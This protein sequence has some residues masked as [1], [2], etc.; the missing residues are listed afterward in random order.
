MRRYLIAGGNEILGENI[1][2]LIYGA[3][4]NV[5]KAFNDFEISVEEYVS[6]KENK[7]LYFGDLDY[8]GIVIYEGLYN[9]VKDKYNIAP[10]INGY[11]QMIDKYIKEE[12]RLPKTKEG[13][14]RNIKNIFLNKFNA[15]YRKKISKILQQ[16]LYIPQEILN[17]KELGM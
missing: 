11:E 1:S 16:D 10:F 6:N 17:I 13:Q 9:L 8:E 15:D 2:T 14:N 7:L 12:I 4:K 5:N 3:G